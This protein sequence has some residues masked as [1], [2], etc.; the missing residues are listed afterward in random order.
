MIFVGGS[1][2]FNDLFKPGIPQ[3]SDLE[4]FFLLFHQE[5]VKWYSLREVMAHVGD[6][7]PLHLHF[8]L[9]SLNHCT[10]LQNNM[11]W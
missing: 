5:R 8:I 6:T 7:V 11:V 4:L 10:L 9:I 1:F 2:T 3:V